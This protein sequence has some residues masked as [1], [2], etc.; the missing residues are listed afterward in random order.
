MPRHLHHLLAAAALTFSL[1]AQL[2]RTFLAQPVVRVACPNGDFALEVT[3]GG[4]GPFRF[5]LDPSDSGD[6]ALDVTLA[7]RLGLLRGRATVRGEPRVVPVRELSLGEATLSGLDLRIENLPAPLRG[8]LGLR[9]FRDVVLRIDRSRRLLEIYRGRLAADRDG[10]F[11]LVVDELPAV[12]AQ[13]GALTLDVGRQTMRRSRAD[14]HLEPP[15]EHRLQLRQS[16]GG[17]LLVR[18]RFDGRQLGWFVFDTGASQTAISNRVAREAGFTAVGTGRTVT[19]TR[20]HDTT[21]WQTRAIEIGSMRVADVRLAGLDIGRMGRYVGGAAGVLGGDVLR[22]CI[23]ELDVATESIT[24][25]DPTRFDLPGIDWQPLTLSKNVPLV[26]ASFEGHDGTFLMDTGDGGTL[27]LFA[28]TV[29]ELGLLDE[30]DVVREEHSEVGGSFE[31]LGGWLESFTLGGHEFLTPPA[32]FATRRA[33]MLGSEIASG[34]FGNSLLAPFTVII[35]YPQQRIAWLR[36]EELRVGER[37][38]DR[39]AG[40]YAGRDQPGCEIRRRGERLLLRLGETEREHELVA[41][42]DTR[43]RMRYGLG[44]CRFVQ[45]RSGETTDV[46]LTH[47]GGERMRLRRQ[48]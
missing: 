11:P 48:E 42:T 37:E 5:V 36:R 27:T 25:H 15:T 3:V 20:V 2:D 26:A 14:R 21:L 7:R 34:S 4:K 18:P 44:R 32:S 17:H 43:F 24:L 6:G 13:C 30:R 38:L 19:P 16:R 28:P 31:L 47:R 41:E 23:V 46:I 45:D 40:I 39:H 8:R 33:G 22:H 35:D 29:H 10:V 12:L 1:P 9:A